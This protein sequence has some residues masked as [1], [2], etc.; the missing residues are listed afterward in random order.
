[1][2]L[3]LDGCSLTYGVGLDYPHTLAGLFAEHGGY[4]VI[5]QSRPGK[6]NIAI[7][8]DTYKHSTPEV[9]VIGWTFSSRFHIGYHD[10]LIDFYSG[11]HG[12]SIMKKSN[13]ATELSKAYSEVYKY[14]YTVFGPPYSDD[15]SD[16][17]IDQTIDS[18]KSRYKKV[19]AFSWEPR[20]TRNQLL[21]PYIAPSLR[22]DDGHLTKQGTQHLYQLI[23]Q[24]LSK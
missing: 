9:Y 3:Y 4:S 2:R 22:Q 1:M 16:M 11:W 8:L 14:F 17:L 23:Q 5:N 7:A 21:Y 10:Q 12:Q 18:L 15:L 19:V 24:E 6:S 13:N 20:Q